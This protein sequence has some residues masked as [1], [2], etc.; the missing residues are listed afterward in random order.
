MNNNGNKKKNKNLFALVLVLVICILLI[1]ICGVAYSKYLSTD[2]G[3]ATAQ[4]AD[5]ICIM[6]VKSSSEDNNGN[7]INPADKTVVNPYCIVTVKNFQTTGEGANQET[8][9]TDTDV[10]YVITVKPKKD[11]NGIDTFEL[12]VYNWYEISSAEATSG[13]KIATSTALSSASTS[14][15]CFKNGVAETRYYKIVFLNSGEQDITRYVDFE[16]NAVQVNAE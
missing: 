9:V 5:M 12:P 6:D 1:I 10:N 14:K 15:G 13:T 7:L 3:S 4:I 8:K 2:R 11:A 16:L